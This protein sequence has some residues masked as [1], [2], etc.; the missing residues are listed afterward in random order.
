MTD[1]E[2]ARQRTQLLKQMREEHEETVKRTQ[3]TRKEQQRIRRAIRDAL[4]SEAKTVP[5]IAEAAGLSAQEVL[6]HVMAMKKYGL[7]DEK[8]MDG[9]YYTY[10]LVKEHGE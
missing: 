6:W 2:E 10:Q 8:E 7:I 5:A 9:Q 1:K 3:E 4:G